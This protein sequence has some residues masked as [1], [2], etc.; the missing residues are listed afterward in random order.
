MSS[1]AK[2]VN[3]LTARVTTLTAHLREHPRDFAALR[4]LRVLLGRRRSLARY[5]E[6]S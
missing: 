6:R 3:D 1:T 4:G 2:Q 5:L